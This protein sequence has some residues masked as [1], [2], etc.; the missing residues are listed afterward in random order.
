MP[1]TFS[2]SRSASP[3]IAKT[4]K[5]HCATGT[6]SLP[7]AAPQLSIDDHAG[8]ANDAHSLAPLDSSPSPETRYAELEQLAT[9]RS[10]IASL[11][12]SIRQALEIQ[13]L[14]D[15]SVKETA[16]QMGLSLSATKSRIFHAKA[17]LRKLLR[18]KVPHRPGTGRPQVSAA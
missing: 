18:P 13:V 14:E 11:R 6:A 4:P 1:D 12:P 8:C 9:V 7:E 2:A 15:R 17:A 5:M 10:A 16:A 3:T